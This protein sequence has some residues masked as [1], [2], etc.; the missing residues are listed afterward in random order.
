MQQV[1]AAWLAHSPACPVCPRTLEPTAIDLPACLR[2]LAGA[3]WKYI[4]GDVFRFPPNLNLFCAIVGAGTQ[5][6][7]VALAIFALS[8][9][10]AYYPYNRGALLTSCVIFYALTAGAPVFWGGPQGHPMHL[11]AAGGHW[12]C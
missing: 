3:G 7:A 9:L 4:H 2:C 6:L 8:L 10:G 12:A 1:T 11:A 5:M